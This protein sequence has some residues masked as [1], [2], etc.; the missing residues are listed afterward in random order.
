[1]SNLID[2]LV[3]TVGAERC[4]TADGDMLRHG[5][6]LYYDGP[7]PTALVRPG[8]IED[9][10]AVVRVATTHGTPV[11]PRG[12]GVSYTAGYVTDR[13]GAVLID[14][15][16]L[17]RAVEVNTADG[18]VTV[19]AGCT[20]SKLRDRLDP[21]GVRTTFQGPFSGAFATVGGALSQ[22]AVVWGAA[23]YGISAAAVLSLSVVTADGTL[24]RTGH[25]A[26]IIPSDGSDGSEGTDDERAN[27]RRAE[28]HFRPYGPDLTG[29]FLG[30]CGA[31]GIKATATLRLAQRPTAT[32]GSTW[33]FPRGDDLVASMV[34]L[35]S[36]ELGTTVVATDSSMA[37]QRIMR[38][39]AER[40]EVVTDPG[41]T[42]TLH[43]VVDGSSAPA[44]GAEAEQVEEVCTRHN[45]TPAPQNRTELLL[46]NPFITMTSSVGP[47][48]ERWAPMHAI[49]PRSG[50][51]TLWARLRELEA[52]HAREIATHEVTVGYLLTT[53]GTEAV[54]IE[55]ALYWPGP[56]RPIHELLL[57]ADQTGGFGDR[58]SDEKADAFVERYR[59]EMA[60]VFRSLGCAH[61]QI[62]RVYP[63][64]ETREAPT[65]ALLRAVKAQLDPQGL[66]NP[67]VLGLG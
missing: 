66:M 19:E 10:Q 29:L 21:L 6:D 8:S 22:S 23:R 25:D 42:H 27:P 20:W 36:R 13:P 55:P 39:A 15:T 52:T 54:I 3:A 50:I 28:P 60:A 34:E 41:F 46:E 17:D 11:V 47:A 62:G 67:G 59:S 63:Y 49:A 5:T 24:L 53:V 1:M 58:E 48:G 31:L 4:S 38:D 57:S 2:A 18:Y 56:R 30:D 37:R 32:I 61:L 64:A 65:L 26:T 45:G 14:T 16:E 33:S 12:G 51:G 7:L 40:G 43:V 44:V 9:L 35:A